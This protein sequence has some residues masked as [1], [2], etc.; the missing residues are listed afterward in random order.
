MAAEGRVDLEAALVA[1]AGAQL[2]AVDLHALAHAD[3]AVAVARRGAVRAGAAVGRPAA[4]SVL[5][6]QSSSTSA[7]RP[8]R[9][10]ADVG[11]RLLEDPVGGEVEA[12]GQLARLARPRQR[13][14]DPG[15][16]ARSDQRARAARARA[17]A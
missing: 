6:C 15:A 14:L 9:V 2:A 4:R 11:Q 3:E 16:F 10:L 13:D 17:G 7:A 1:R 8:A 12:G 5:G